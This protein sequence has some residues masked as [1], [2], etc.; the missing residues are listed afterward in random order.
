[1]K[2]RRF[3]VEIEFDSCGL[4]RSGVLSVLREAFD[5]NGLRRWY[6]DR[7]L[8]HDGS[9]FELRT[10]I[11]RGKDGF[12]KLELVMDTLANS[13]CDV[14]YEDGMHIHHDAP[15]YVRNIDNCIRLVKSWEANKH[16]I[17]K[18]VNPDRTQDSYG[19]VYA[20][21]GHWACP[22]WTKDEIARLELE[23]KIPTFERKDLNLLAL[24][25]HGTVEI[26]LHEG[27]LNFKQAESW[28]KFGQKLL[29]RCA[30]HSMKDSRDEE[31]LLKKIRV[32]PDARRVLVNKSKRIYG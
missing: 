16:I 9:E 27:T 19:D 2:D 31:S 17:Y 24:N 15:E 10:P 18:F 1:M 28:I 29:D 3:G 32:S 7:R 14:T 26:R 20:E 13:G 8:D 21:Y 12:D 25:E 22:P 4:E 30:L 6:F 23:K 5:K 11:L